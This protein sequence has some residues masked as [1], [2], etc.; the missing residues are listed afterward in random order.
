MNVDVTIYFVVLRK[1]SSDC[2]E[3]DQNECFS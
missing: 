1:I 2:M 3:I